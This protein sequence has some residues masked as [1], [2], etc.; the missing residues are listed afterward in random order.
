MCPMT[1]FFSFPKMHTSIIPLKAFL[2]SWIFHSLPY[3]YRSFTTLAR[4]LATAFGLRRPNQA[5]KFI[6]FSCSAA[7]LPEIGL[8]LFS[9][10]STGAGQN[11]PV[12]R[13]ANISRCKTNFA[14]PKINVTLI[15][16]SNGK[17]EE[18]VRINAQDRWSSRICSDC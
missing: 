4:G 7:P 16:Q 11:R 2:I 17:Y 18:Q 3:L 9:C 10:T 1:L 8:S 5:R 15:F 14:R 12:V 13:T 6:I